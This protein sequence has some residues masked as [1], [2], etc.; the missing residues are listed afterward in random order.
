MNYRRGLLRVYVV[1]AV[2][3]IVFIGMVAASR[4]TL[5]WAFIQQDDWPSLEPGQVELLRLA[6]LGGLLF[7]PPAI[8]YAV[9]F[10][11][12]PWIYRGFKSAPHN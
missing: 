2:C 5:L 9:I 7:V 6:W 11:L 8:G 3:W 4:R 1:G 12:I 10:I